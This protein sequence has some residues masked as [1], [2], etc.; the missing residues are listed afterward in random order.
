MAAKCSDVCGCGQD[1]LPAT[2][3]PGLQKYT[4]NHERCSINFLT[5]LN[6]NTIFDHQIIG[7]PAELSKIRA[8]KHLQFHIGY[9]VKI[10]ASILVVL[11]SAFYTCKPI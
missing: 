10:C 3:K 11:Q 1:S 9:V 6:L 7:Q 2:K 8:D 4:V 5:D